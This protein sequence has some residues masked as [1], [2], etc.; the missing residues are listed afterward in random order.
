[1][2]EGTLWDIGIGKDFIQTHRIEA[3]VENG[4]NA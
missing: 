1:V 3:F 4:S 2:V